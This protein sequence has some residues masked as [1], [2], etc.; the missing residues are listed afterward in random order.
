MNSLSFLEIGCSPDAFLTEADLIL[1]KSF[2]AGSGQRFVPAI[3]RKHGD[4]QK[5]AEMRGGRT[6]EVNS[7]V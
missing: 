3:S 1:T 4:E 2:I 7:L 6:N 5:E